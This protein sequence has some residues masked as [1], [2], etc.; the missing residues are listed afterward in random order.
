MSTPHNVTNGTDRPL[1]VSLTVVQVVDTSTLAPA[2]PDLSGITHDP[3]TGDLV[4]TDAEIEE[5]PYYESAR[6]DVW[7]V[8]TA[9]PPA[10]T[11]TGGA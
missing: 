8:T 10:Q 4:F 6:V 7:S 9:A 1:A 5:Y 2:S 3:G 11:A